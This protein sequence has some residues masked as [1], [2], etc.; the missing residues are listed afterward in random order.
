[1]TTTPV[2][3]TAEEIADGWKPHDGGK[4]PVADETVVEVC[5]FD[6]TH[7]VTTALGDQFQW[8]HTWA[9][10]R[11]EI[12]AFC[13]VKYR[14]F[15][16]V[17]PANQALQA[18]DRL[19][20]YMGYKER[21]SDID[22]IRAALSRNLTGLGGDG[23]DSN[24]LEMPLRFAIAML[25]AARSEYEETT[26]EDANPQIEQAIQE[27]LTALASLTV[28]VSGLG[29]AWLTERDIEIIEPA[30]VIASHYVLERGDKKAL[31]DIEGIR[32]R[33]SPEIGLPSLSVSDPVAGEGGDLIEKLLD[34]QQDINLAANSYMDQSLCE[35]SA[36]I[37]K[38]EPILRR[39][40]SASPSP[41]DVQGWQMVPKEPTEEMIE[42]GYDA[43]RDH[44]G[45]PVFADAGF[46]IGHARHIFR[47]MLSAAPQPADA[48][49]G[50]IADEQ[51]G[52]RVLVGGWQ[53][54]SGNVAGYWWWHDD[55][56]IDGKAFDHP[57]AT[58]FWPAPPTPDAPLPAAPQT[59][60]EQ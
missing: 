56:I 24:P 38:I 42:A 36:L 60:G 18:L 1:M 26:D 8:E 52:M 9:G 14:V 46:C 7:H 16:P 5:D 49:W 34:A 17:Q 23:E 57:K 15:A 21:A 54:R 41:V 2:E 10:P 22:L 47:A 44:D 11:D 20:S 58:H 31:A 59:G 13:V 27:G 4:C 45:N 37:D 30:L 50:P 6:N 53:R 29:G 3:L 32:K 48:G 28:P 35:A 40:L 51:N 39:A 33:L 25:R 43:T 19:D 55:V 12:D